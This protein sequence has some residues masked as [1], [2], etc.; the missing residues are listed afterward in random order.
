MR[1]GKKG[2]DTR[3]KKD[4]RKGKQGGGGGS[5]KAKI[6]G[7]LF[8]LAN[9]PNS[10]IIIILPDLVPSTSNQPHLAEERETLTSKKPKLSKYFLT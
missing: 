7:S 3:E 8:S 10:N 4:W 5:S 2:W 9:P 1:R 6:D